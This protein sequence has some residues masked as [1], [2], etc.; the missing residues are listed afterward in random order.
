[1]YS[2]IQSHFYHYILIGYINYNNGGFLSVST[3]DNYYKL[4]YDKS[5]HEKCKV[6]IVGGGIAGSYLAMRL[7]KKYGSDICLFDKDKHT[8]GRMYDI[9]VNSKTSRSPKIGLGGRR[10]LAAQEVMTNLAKELKIKLEKPRPLEEFWFSRGKYDFANRS[11]DEDPFAGLYP[12][13]K[14]NRSDPDYLSQLTQT[15]LN[16]PERKNIIDH[17]NLRSYI[18]SAI[19][20]AGYQF[21]YDMYRFKSNYIH[22][23]AAKDYIDWLDNDYSLGIDDMYP[24]GGMSQYAKKALKKAQKFGARIFKPERIISIN[25][26]RYSGYRLS[27]PQRKILADKVIIAAPAQAFNE[28]QGDIID[29][30]RSHSPFEYILGAPVM[31]ITQWYENAWWMRIKRISNGRRVWRAWT[32]DS[33]ISSIEIP[34]EPYLKRQKV[35]R[36]AYADDPACIQHFNFLKDSN[37]TKLEEKVR[38]GLKH[39]FANNGITTR[40]KI[41]KATKTVIQNWPAAWYWVKAGSP[42]SAR[43]IEHWA[44]KPLEGENVGLASDSYLSLRAG[45]AEGAV[46]SAM[47]LLKRQYPDV[48][49]PLYEVKTRLD[50]SRFSS[51][52]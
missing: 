27:S 44:S 8:G 1:M 23:I 25:K 51:I 33:C 21:I 34:R 36:T 9:P 5:V 19:G 40:I 17:P 49:D 13:L 52:S 20:D 15:L 12:G 48:I 29:A 26:D 42:F 6:A 2:K 28:I 41:P 32:T 11:N 31:A 30:I 45:W 35:F 10:I 7:S 22:P 14:I 39:L 18:A 4:Y 47:Q 24:V 50:E 46:L 16:S 37:I 3:L 43:Y 38:N